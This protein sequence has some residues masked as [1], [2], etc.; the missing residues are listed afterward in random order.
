MCKINLI[1]RL[2]I[3]IYHSR[4]YVI[5][6]LNL[7]FFNFIREKNVQSSQNYQQSIL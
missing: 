3:N 6:S 2:I 4:E 7:S 1:K 5:S